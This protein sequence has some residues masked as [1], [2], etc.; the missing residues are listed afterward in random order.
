MHVMLERIAMARNATACAAWAIVVALVSATAAATDR[1]FVTSATGSGNLST[2]PQADGLHGISAG[3]RICQNLAAAAGLAGAATFRAW[4]SSSATDAACNIKARTGHL[5]TCGSIAI[6][7][8]GPWARTDGAPFARNVAAL[9]AGE[10][11]TT[12]R[13]DENGNEVAFEELVWTG[14]DASGRWI[15]GRDCADDVGGAWNDEAAPELGGTGLVGHGPVRWTALTG[16]SCNLPFGHLYC[17]QHSLF[18][19]PPF[20]P[21]EGEGALVFRTSVAY[22]GEL[23]LAAE[24]GGQV[25]LAAGDAI[26]R[27][28]AQAGNLPNPASFRAWL[29]TASTSAALHLGYDGPMKR[30]DGIPVAVSLADLTDGELIAPIAQTEL[31]AYGSAETWTGT[32]EIGTFNETNCFD[33]TIAVANV[34][35][36]SG[37]ASGIRRWSSFS[38]LP[39]DRLQ[40]LYCFSSTPILFASGF[41]E[42]GGALWRWSAVAP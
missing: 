6:N 24:A 3:N 34:H 20:E 42:S 30:P 28:R 22:S 17:F 39:C 8:P 37:R 2:W 7:N 26:C 1:M 9:T 33:W 31:L 25:S 41:E 29:S 4:L 36:V 23:A 11:L 12:A 21:F 16:A 40:S 14:T 38:E 10:V 32:D 15:A 13:F 35:G 27:A 5:P 18:G 19:G